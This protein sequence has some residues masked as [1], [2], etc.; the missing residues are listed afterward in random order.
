M[1]T[2]LLDGTSSGTDGDYQQ[3]RCYVVEGR[4]TRNATGP[5]GVSGSMKRFEPF[6][7]ALATT[8][9]AG[10]ALLSLAE[11]I[12]VPVANV[13]SVPCRPTRPEPAFV[14]PAP[15]PKAPPD[16]YGAAWYGDPA[17]WTML[18]RDGEI[19]SDLPRD[20][21]GY[22]Q[23]TFWWSTAW[24]PREEQQPA[25]TVTGTRL[26]GDSSFSAGSPGTN[27]TADFGTAMLVGVDIPAAG[28]WRL[29][30]AYRGAR[31][32]YVVLV[33]P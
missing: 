19:W 16:Y 6:A 31:L 22:G 26:D 1:R 17:L 13:G 9:L 30:G 23:K 8:V 25:I 20:E 11:P 24:T 14:A 33:K 29:T 28:C 32:S 18:D 15:F 4:G 27:A 3:L 5:R 2:P 21:H 12:G 7:A 10:C